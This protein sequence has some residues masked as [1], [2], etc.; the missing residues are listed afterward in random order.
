MD[1]GI[2]ALIAE[3]DALPSVDTADHLSRLQTL[4]DRYF[5]A[6]DAAD[7][8]G[9]WFRLYERFPEDDGL[10][11]F[12]FILHKIETYS[13]YNGLVVES[14]RRRPSQFPV[15]MLHRLLN[16]GVRRVGDVELLEL[17]QCV[18]ADEQ[19]LPSVR[20]SAAGFIEHQQGHSELGAAP[21]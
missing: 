19:C 13:E 15:M 1:E 21:D 8:L 12:W 5:A 20:K 11:V 7:H 3:I 10:G 2:E 6:P 4:A 14:V 9:V 17:L 18:A 16:A